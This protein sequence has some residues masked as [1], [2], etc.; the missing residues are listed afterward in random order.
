[1]KLSVLSRSLLLAAL[2]SVALVRAETEPTT[3]KFSDPSKPGTVKIAVARGEIR[4]QGADTKE[5]LIKADA[6]ARPKTA[7][8]D[9]L[10][11]LTE[12]ATYSLNEKNNVISIDAFSDSWMGGASDFQITVPR[13]TNVI[14]SNAFGGDIRC[15]DLTGDVEVKSLNSQ[16]RLDDLSGGVLVET[17]NGEVVANVRELNANKPLSITSTN[18]TVSLHVPADLKA[19]VRMRT[20]NGS[21]L[22]DFDDKVL[23]TKVEATPGRGRH[24]GHMYLPPEAQAAIREATRVGI[25]AAHEAAE[26]VREAADAAREAAQEARRE[27]VNASEDDDDNDKTVIVEHPEAPEPPERPE[28]PEQPETPDVAP[29]PPVPTI[30]SIPAVTGGKLVTGTLN[31]GG[32]E[33]NIAT[34]NGDVTLRRLEPKK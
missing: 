27:H 11:V 22:T 15:S 18:G 14:V 33:I 10:R 29:M 12:S 5:V 2:A 19:N 31:G 8:K 7:R 32:P 21:I 25:Q 3:V 28:Q 34:M 26:A 20:Q 23:V 13:G 9:G 16:V 4:V 1:M 6:P 17:T 30:P 24:H